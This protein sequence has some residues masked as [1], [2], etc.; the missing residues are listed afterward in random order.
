M[1]QRK[2]ILQQSGK[3]LKQNPSEAY[4]TVDELHEM[5]ASNNSTLFMSKVSRHVGNIA[6]IE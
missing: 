3:F 6:G 5:T 2:R 4:L 1:I